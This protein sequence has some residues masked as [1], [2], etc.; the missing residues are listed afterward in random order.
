MISFIEAFKRELEQESLGTKKMLAIIP[1][2]KLDWQPHPK[3]MR[4]K[5]LASHL[6][7]IPDMISNGL[8]Q[9]KWDME[10]NPYVTKDMNSAEEFLARYEESLKDAFE[11][12]DQ[13]SED[14]LQ[15]KWKLCA[16]E[17][18]YL[19]LEKWEVCRHAMGQNAHHR[20]QLGVFLRLLDVPIP[21]PYG[22]STDETF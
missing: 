19:E 16:G 2:D 12:L 13:T 10:A 14:V 4:I 6:A 1:A 7:E 15:H 8:K 5:A 11:A 20:A 22:P 9:E 3:S 21:G 17:E 18:T